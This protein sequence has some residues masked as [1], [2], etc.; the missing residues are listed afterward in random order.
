VGVIA[1]CTCLTL[2]SIM[3]VGI[4]APYQLHA[5]R[6][7]VQQEEQN[8]PAFVLP[9]VLM[10]VCALVCQNGVASTEYDMPEAD[11][12]KAQRRRR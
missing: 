4:P 10:L 6:A 1:R 3:P 12:K 2:E 11:C 7:D 9:D 8:A 5:A